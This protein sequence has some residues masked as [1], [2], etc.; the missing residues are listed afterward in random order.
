MFKSYSFV[1]LS[2]LTITIYP[3]ASENTKSTLID[4]HQLLPL[5][6]SINPIFKFVKNKSNQT[7]DYVFLKKLSE[8][9][10]RPTMIKINL[11]RGDSTH[12]SAGLFEHLYILEERME[13]IKELQKQYENLKNISFYSGPLV[14]SLKELNQ[15]KGN[16]L[17]YIDIV[18]KNYNETEKPILEI[19]KIIFSLGFKNTTFIFNNVHMFY[20][21]KANSEKMFTDSYPTIDDILLL[22]FSYD[23]HYKCA[24]IYDTLLIYPEHLPITVSP[25]VQCITLS[26]LYNEQNENTYSLDTLIESERHIA[27]SCGEEYEALKELYKVYVQAWTIQSGSSRHIAL[28]HGLT[29]L[30]HENFKDARQQFCEAKLR[31]NGEFG[32]RIDWYLAMAEAECFFGIRQS[33]I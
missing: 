8:H 9:L 3:S 17:F 25:L 18:Q 12:D 4:Y 33:L 11:L 14:N 21:T 1:I 24:L 30:N 16:L 19:L 6:D 15:I 20:K 2:L 26:R 5:T 7:L 31:G 29:Q 32:W 23:T 13:A 28:W 22:I 27:N 10:Q